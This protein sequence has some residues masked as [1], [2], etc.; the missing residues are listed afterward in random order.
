MNNENE[1][2][3]TNAQLLTGE[4]ET[5]SLNEELKNGNAVAFFSNDVFLKVEEGDSEDNEELDG[6]T[7]AI[8]YEQQPVSS[9]KEVI[10]LLNIDGTI[11][12]INIELLNSAPA[13]NT[14]PKLERFYF[15]VKAN[16]CKLCSFLSETVQDISNH[17][18]AEHAK[19]IGFENHEDNQEN[20]I[21]TKMTSILNVNKNKQKYTMFLCSGC[22]NAYSN[23]EDLKQHMITVSAE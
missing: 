20:I 22:G 21:G 18:M 13:K 11:T 4:N 14:C 2:I 3:S 6:N 15:E 23:K 19:E 8:S 1:S 9:E 16:K 10:Q 17:L 12:T 7:Y 5:T